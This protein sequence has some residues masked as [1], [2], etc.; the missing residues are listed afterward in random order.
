MLCG[1]SEPISQQSANRPW[2]F[3]KGQSGNPSG[4]PRGLEAL[5]RQ[6]TEEALAVLVEA[7]HDSDRRIAVTA[8]GMLL[9]RG[10]GKPAQ[11]VSGTTDMPTI[12]QLMHREAAAAFSKELHAEREERERQLRAPLV[13]NGEATKSLELKESTP[14]DL[15]APALE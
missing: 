7:L 13:I 4:R 14:I 11:A 12:L 8:A 6:H 9:D 3:Q 15:M 2:L 1:M 10:W 5:A